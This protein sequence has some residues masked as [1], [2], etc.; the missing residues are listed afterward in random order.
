MPQNPIALKTSR[1]QPFAPPGPLSSKLSSKLSKEAAEL[2]AGWKR[3]EA[4]VSELG[5]QHV[6]LEQKL[7]QARADLG[8]AQAREVASFGRDRALGAAERVAALEVEV[9]SRTPVS[10]VS[11]GE[12]AREQAEGARGAYSAFLAAHWKALTEEHR[13]LAEKIHKPYAAALASFQEATA[14]L[15]DEH[16]ELCQSL[17]HVIGGT[18]PFLENDLP[19]TTRELSG[20]E[21]LPA[22]SPESLE[23]RQ[24]WE[25]AEAER[26]R[27]FQ[28]KLDRE[29]AERKRLE[30]GEPARYQSITQVRELAEGVAAAA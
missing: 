30:N 1:W 7:Q 23:R 14:G 15:L 28:E 20:Y 16:D 22:P 26:G 25:V 11:L 9:K 5:Q 19:R 8:R 18:E 2:Y 12:Q 3:A 6:E 10:G 24:A 13:A 21:K 4:Y 17:R 29:N 27:L